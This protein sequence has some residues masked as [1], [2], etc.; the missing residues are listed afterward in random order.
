MF[1][2]KN[3][4]MKKLTET[5]FVMFMAIIAYSCGGTKQAG[6]KQ[7]TFTGNPLIRDKFT[8]DPAPM[9]YDGEARNS[10]SPNGSV[11]PHPT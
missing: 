6:E 1:N 5:L 2:L 11:T 4:H 7:F 9:V 10:T 3:N 8:A